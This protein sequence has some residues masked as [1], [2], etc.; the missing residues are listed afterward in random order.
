MRESASTSTRRIRTGYW[1]SPTTMMVSSRS[2]SPST[3]LA[4]RSWYGRR[5]VRDLEQGREGRV[6]GQSP[7]TSTHRPLRVQGIEPRRR[8]R[9]AHLDPSTQPG[10]RRSGVLER[11]LALISLMADTEDEAGSADAPVLGVEVDV[12]GPLDRLVRPP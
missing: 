11:H 1:S 12:D 4:T 7:Q 10:H 3:S 5:R 9:F 8:E 2:T 6:T